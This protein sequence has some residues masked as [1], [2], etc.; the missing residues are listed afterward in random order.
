MPGSSCGNRFD[1]PIITERLLVIKLYRHSRHRAP[2]RVLLLSSPANG[3]NFSMRLRSPG[4][5]RELP[6]KPIALSQLFALSHTD[7]LL[8]D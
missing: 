5:Y 3:D 8:V 6:G 4:K 1:D 2:F 7:R